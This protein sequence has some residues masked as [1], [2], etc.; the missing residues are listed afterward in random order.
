[1][2]ELVRR[3]RDRVNAS[4]E[5]DRVITRAHAFL[6]GPEPVDMA[7]GSH[8]QPVIDQRPR[9]VLTA[10]VA[11]SGVLG[12]LVIAASAP[13]WRLAVPTWRLTLPFIGHP[14]SSTE[15]TLWF[16]CGLVLLAIGWLGLIHRMGR[17][18]STKRALIVAG[19]VIV[20]WAIPVSLGPPLLSNDVYSYVAQGEMSSRGIDPSRTGPVELGWGDFTTGADPVWRAAPAPYG[21]VAVAVS[22]AAVEL[23]GHRQVGAIAWYRVF[24]WI[25][26]AMA[27]VGIGL[28]AL[29][30]GLSPAVAIAIGVG[31]PIVI[32]HLIGGAHNDA[33]MFGLLALGLAAVQRNRR[34]L[35][36][37]LLIAATAVK[38]PAAIALVYVG[39]C[40]R[41]VVASWKERIVT[42]LGVLAAAVVTIVIGC[43]LIGLGPGWI[44]ALKSTGKVNDT[45]SP[46]TK[47]GFSIAEVLDMIGLHVDGAALAAGVRALGLLA[48]AILVLVMLIR[49]PRVGVVRATA[50]VLVGYV[51]LGPVIWPWYFAAGF[52]L[53]A[54]CGLGRYRPSFLVVCIAVSWFVWPTSVMSFGTFGGG[55]QHLRGLGVVIGVIALAVGAQWWAGRHERRFPEMA[56]NAVGDGAGRDRDGSLPV[57]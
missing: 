51:V 45:Y 2:L 43:A 15:S 17:I 42:T 39:W 6:I 36:V 27:A 22:R 8:W 33:L 50:V 53:L 12:S 40:W 34:A 48:T 10:L 16:L 26:V 11:L 57:P 14:G 9:P 35:G 28:I 41:P 1:M 7:D 20:L 29:R 18:A 25:G 13:L 56:I 38:L 24:V 3:A 32:L 49:S 30:N 46:T 21:P 23:S 55:Y 37:A 4:P 47:I 52:G 5:I 44:T 54:A 19:S 31:N